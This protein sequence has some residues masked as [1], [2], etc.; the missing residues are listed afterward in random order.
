[1]QNLTVYCQPTPRYKDGED[2]DGAIS[3]IEMDDEPSYMF[4]MQRS[5]CGIDAHLQ[6]IF[7]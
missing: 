6:E 2:D 1:M 5:Q 7:A 3:V 4:D